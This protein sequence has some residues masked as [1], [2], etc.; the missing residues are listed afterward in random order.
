MIT[1]KIGGNPVFPRDKDN[2]DIEFLNIFF[3]YCQYLCKQKDEKII[4]I[5]GG[6]GGQVFIEWGQ[7]VGCSEGELNEVG[8]VLI[9]TSAKILSRMAR[10]FIYSKEDVCPYVALTASDLDTAICK[11]RVILSGVSM[12]GAVTSD[13]LSALVAEHTK[14]KLF[15]IKNGRPYPKETSFYDDI[16]YKNINFYKLSKFIID[17]DKKMLAGCH[18][19]IDYMCLKIMERYRCET[20]I[21]VKK[22][23]FEWNKINEID[24]ISINF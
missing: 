18:P 15:F 9:N 12:Q 8:C 22:D 6:I 16:D 19:S 10:N 24:G 3:E 1:I 4:I 7:K 23:F 11:Y 17:H 14:S 21:L 20:K 2:I 5:P 13:S